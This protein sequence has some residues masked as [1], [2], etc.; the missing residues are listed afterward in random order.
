MHAVITYKLEKLEFIAF[1]LLYQE[2]RWVDKDVE[3]SVS[4]LR[5]GNR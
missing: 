3:N 1:H 4:Q 5:C 2:Y